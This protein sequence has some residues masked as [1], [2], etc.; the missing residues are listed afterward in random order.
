MEEAVLVDDLFC[1]LWIL[2]IAFHHIES[3]TAHLTLYTNRTFLACF[4][5]EHFHLY[6]REVATYG[7]ATLLE[8]I[9]QTSLRHTWRRLGESIDAGDGHIHLLRYLLH[10]LYRTETACHNARTQT[11]QIKHRE[12]RVVQLSY[13]HRGD[14][15]QSRTP[16]FMDRGQHYQRVELL[17]HHFGTAVRQTVHRSEH[18]TEAVEQRHTDAQFVVLGE[19]HILTC[20]IAVVGNAVMSEHHALGETC[21]TTGILHIADIVAVNLTLHLQKGL[22]LDVL[23]QQQQLGRI[24]HTAIFLHTYI[25]YILQVGELL[26]V[27]VAA[28]AGLQLRQH[29]IGHIDI[30]TVPRTIGDT[31][32][33]HIRVLTQILQ[34]VLLVTGVYRNQDGTNLGGSIEEG[35]PVGH[36]GCPDADVRAFLD[37]DGDQTFGQ[38]IDTF[39]E[40]RPSKSEVTV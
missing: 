28:F 22:V 11:G 18:H 26:A 1:S 36:I 14:A 38:I 29:L 13:K 23:T 7:G 34:L 5:I 3:A 17:D 2:V 4:R 9:V 20:K 15:V 31:E 12:H 27:Q 16:F 30:V 21:G 32:R 8:G 25:Y 39:V 10:Q 33:V 24:E 40:L 37:T 19:A 35:Q 6:K